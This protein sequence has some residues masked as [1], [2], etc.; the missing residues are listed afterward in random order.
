IG[1]LKD[2]TYRAVECLKACDL[3]LAEDTRTTGKLLKEYGIT[4][5]M[6]SYHMFNEHKKDDE[7]T[8]LLDT[9]VYVC[10]VSDAVK[11]GISVPGYLLIRNCVQNG[12]NVI[13][14]PGATAFVPAL[15]SSGLPCDKFYF[16]GFLP[17]KKG[18]Q[19]RLL[20]L[21]DEPQT[22]VFYESPH[23]LI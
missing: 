3:I 9:D 6:K 22:I 5:Q 14:L 8:D 12:I 10:L 21:C 20:K 11:P 15:V 7:L 18:R 19:T 2:I 16:E 23:R 1:N 4:T 17:H 13:T